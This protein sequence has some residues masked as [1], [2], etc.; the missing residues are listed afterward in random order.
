LTDFL[1]LLSIDIKRW[2]LRHWQI[3]TISKITKKRNILNFKF[4]NGGMP[5]FT[6]ISKHNAMNAER[7]I[8]TVDKEPRSIF[9]IAT[10][11][12]FIIFTISN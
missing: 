8:A 10:E 11:T 7:S 12:L 6:H 3:K 9:R 4:S 2:N 5:E 1:F